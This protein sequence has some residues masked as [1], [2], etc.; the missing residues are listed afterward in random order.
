[1]WGPNVPKRQILQNSNSAL[2]PWK[3]L[4]FL[5]ETPAKDHSSELPSAM[6]LAVL[7]CLWKH[8]SVPAT[9]TA[10]SFFLHLRCRTEGFSAA[11][12]QESQTNPLYYLLKGI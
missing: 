2:L 10:V 4:G 12:L 1:M 6:G 11:Y 8:L 5:G 3:R 7:L 9:Q